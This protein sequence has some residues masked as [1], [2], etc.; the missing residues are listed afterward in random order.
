MMNQWISD[1]IIDHCLITRDG[2]CINRQGFG[3][4]E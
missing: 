1:A 2:A 4:R 3:G